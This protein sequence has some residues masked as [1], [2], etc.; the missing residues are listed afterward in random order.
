MRLVSLIVALSAALALIE[1]E[2][3]NASPANNRARQ[4][5]SDDFFDI[6]GSG[7]H[8]KY[9]LNILEHLMPARNLHTR[10]ISLRYRFYK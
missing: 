4:S 2:I 1:Q 5:G 9:C 8:R 7:R 10:K 3:P 6:E